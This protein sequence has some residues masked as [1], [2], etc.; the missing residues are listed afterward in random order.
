MNAL[1]LL[2]NI[3]CFFLSFFFFFFSSLNGFAFAFSRAHL[4]FTILL[5]LYSV[6]RV[7][8]TLVLLYISIHICYACI[9][10]FLIRSFVLSFSIAF[11]YM[12][13][14]AAFKN[15]FAD[16]MACGTIIDSG[17]KQTNKT[18]QKLK[19]NGFFARVVTPSRD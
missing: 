8:F 6:H 13:K 1:A 4:L 10:L 7:G 17:K 14:F 5:F 9:F 3:V 18:N 15:Q 11:V 19:H 16:C 12:S 2:H